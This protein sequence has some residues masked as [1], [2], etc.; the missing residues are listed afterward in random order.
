M[1]CDLESL[2]VRR[3]DPESGFVTWRSEQ[4]SEMLVQLLGGAASSRM[5]D[6][7]PGDG[8]FDLDADGRTDVELLDGPNLIR[9]LGG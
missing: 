8:R 2:R 9:A 1:V 3:R 4:V 7:L 6:V 5:A